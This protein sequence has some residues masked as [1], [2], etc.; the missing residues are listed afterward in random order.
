MSVLFGYVPVL[1]ARPPHAAMVPQGGRAA[2]QYKLPLGWN[3]LFPASRKS[4]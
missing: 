3:G 2:N 1:V 4:L